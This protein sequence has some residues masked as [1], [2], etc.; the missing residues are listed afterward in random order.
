MLAEDLRKQVEPYGISQADIPK[1]EVEDHTPVLGHWDI[2]GLAQAIRYQLVF[3]GVEFDD[4]YHYHSEDQQATQDS[5]DRKKDKLGLDFPALP[6]FIDGKFKAT[7]HL[8]IHQY[9]ADKWMPELLGKTKKAKAQVDCMAG[10]ISG[11]RKFIDDTCLSGDISQRRLA[12]EIITK[13]EPV[14]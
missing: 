4:F 2:R 10:V 9:V 12:G 7:S 6:Y 14:A 5:W 11:V 8:A 3:C 1:E 13:M